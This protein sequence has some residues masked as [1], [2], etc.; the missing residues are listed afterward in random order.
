MVLLRAYLP[1]RSLLRLD[2]GCGI[3]S[4]RRIVR[5]YGTS[6]T[7]K[8]CLNSNTTSPKTP[9]VAKGSMSC[10]AAPGGRDVG[11]RLTEGCGLM[12]ARWST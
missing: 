4:F 2:V 3:V 10:G 1:E 6:S 9:E 5:G 7:E 8:I 11:G 12:L